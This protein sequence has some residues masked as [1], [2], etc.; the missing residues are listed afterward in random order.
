MIHDMTDLIESYLTTAPAEELLLFLWKALSKQGETNIPWK[1]T[2]A[3]FDGFSRSKVLQKFILLVFFPVGRNKYQP[4]SQHT[5]TRST[6][7]Q[8]FAI[9]SATHACSITALKV[10]LHILMS[11]QIAAEAR[12]NT[13]SRAGQLDNCPFSSALKCIRAM[14]QHS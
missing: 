9:A 4:A 2:H 7:S 11:K 5:L 8:R 12:S 6:A 14:R 10:V 3:P 13:L 1:T